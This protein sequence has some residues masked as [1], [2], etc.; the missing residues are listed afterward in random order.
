MRGCSDS[1]LSDVRP[2][3]SEM[4]VCSRTTTVQ[5]A[6]AQLQNGRRPHVRLAGKTQNQKLNAS[7]VRAAIARATVKINGTRG[8]I[9]TNATIAGAKAEAAS[10]SIGGAPPGPGSQETSPEGIGSSGETAAPMAAAAGK[11]K[12]VHGATRPATIAAMDATG[13]EAVLIH[14]SS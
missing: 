7:P 3:Q 8:A 12:A 11:A 4:R 1:D 5:S 14:H 2:P 13:A 9:D 6:A 10:S